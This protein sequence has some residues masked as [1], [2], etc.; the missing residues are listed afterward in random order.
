MTTVPGTSSR[1]GTVPRTDEQRGLKP[2]ELEYDH[3]AVEALGFSAEDAAWR[4]G[5]GYASQGSCAACRRP[6]RLEDDLPDT[7]VSRKPS[8]R[9]EVA[10]Y[11]QPVVVPLRKASV[12]YNSREQVPSR[13]PPPRA[14]FSSA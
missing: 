8:C 11:P 3:V 5:I 9:Q 13:K 14:A 2:L 10:R 7:S 12:K 6:I 4:F 1:K